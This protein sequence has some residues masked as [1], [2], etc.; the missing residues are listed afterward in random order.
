MLI[1]GTLFRRHLVGRNDQV[2]LDGAGTRRSVFFKVAVYEVKPAV[3]TLHGTYSRDFPP[4]LTIDSGDTVRFTT[5]E[6]RWNLEPPRDD[7]SQRK[8]EPRDP[9]RDVG[10]ALLG[11]IEIRGAETGMTLAVR[12][13]EIRVGT[14]GWTTAGGGDFAVNR[15]VG[16]EN[17]PATRLQWQLDPDT[18]T[19]RNQFGH[20]VKLRPFM[21]QMGMPPDEPGLHSTRPP[22]Y[23][24]GNLDC[25]ELVSGSTLYLPIPVAGGLF[26]VG[27]GH[28]LQ[29]D[30]EVAG[31]AIECPMEGVELTFFFEPGL[32]L[33]MPRA[34]T[35]AGWVTMGLHEDLHEAMMIA[36]RGMLDLMGEQIGRAS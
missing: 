33:T 25:K 30:G 31:V 20:E 24:G 21:G 2:C 14:W 10:H 34:H 7:E 16:L 19:G 13:D 4:I 1:F 26:S 9:K 11:P 18:Q 6:S 23:C 36:L 8:F 3:D 12:I 5:L 22:R 29:A 15:S 27:D 28:A 17:S 35:P 32:R